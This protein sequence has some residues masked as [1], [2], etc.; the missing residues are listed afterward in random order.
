MYMSPRIEYNFINEWVQKLVGREITPIN[1]VRQMG[2]VLNR[3]YPID[4]KLHSAEKLKLEPGQF[5]FGG[6]YD[7]DADEKGFKQFSLGLFMNHPKNEKMLITQRIADV[8]SIELIEAL[9]HEYEHQRQYRSR[10]YRSIKHV[11]RSDGKTYTEKEMKEYLGHP[12][13][14]DAFATNIA[15]RL[16]LYKFVYDKADLAESSD[17]HM[18]YESFGRRHPLTKL[19]ERRIQQKLEY[20]KENDNGKPHRRACKRIGPRRTRSIR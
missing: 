14:I 11:Y 15:A 8:M 5:S 6:E 3:R 18:Y 12:D 1:L 9:L 19:V 13:E 20:F 4:V 10:R 16:Y 17:L 2:R 7:V